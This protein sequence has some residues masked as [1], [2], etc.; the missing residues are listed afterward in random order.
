MKELAGN[1]NLIIHTVGKTNL[2][3][4]KFKEKKIENLV[5]K[6]NPDAHGFGIE[7]QMSIRALKYK[8]KIKEIS[9]I[10]RERIGGRST[11][12]TFEVGWYF[13]RLL[14]KE[15]LNK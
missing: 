6:I 3:N 4:I 5:K 11:A 15:L 14:F 10:E 12:G 9:T 2:I 8:M 13:I 7:F 1:A